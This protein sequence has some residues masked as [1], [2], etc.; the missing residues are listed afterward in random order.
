[1]SQ[2]QYV[3]GMV[4]CSIL[5]SRKLLSNIFC[6]KQLYETVT[7]LLQSEMFLKMLYIFKNCIW[8]RT[9]K[10]RQPILLVFKQF[11]Y[12]LKIVSLFSSYT[13]KSAK[14]CTG[15]F[16]AHVKWLIITWTLFVTILSVVPILYMSLKLT[17]NDCHKDEILKISDSSNAVIIS[18]EMCMMV[19]T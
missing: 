3:T 17:V 16:Q 7:R 18:C 14:I 4:S 15:L 11:V 2:V 6:F 9:P 12:M 19:P 8:K 1:M 5:L 10:R 13:T